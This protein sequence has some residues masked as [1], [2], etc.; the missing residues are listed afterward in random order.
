MKLKYSITVALITSIFLTNNSHADFTGDPA[1]GGPMTTCKYYHTVEGET[2]S[3]SHHF[4]SRIVFG[5]PCPILAPD[6]DSDGEIHEIVGDLD[7]SDPR[8]ID[9]PKVRQKIDDRHCVITID[10]GNEI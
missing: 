4:K 7:P 8:Y 1:L 6:P 2:V 5:S 9:S 3:P 10:T